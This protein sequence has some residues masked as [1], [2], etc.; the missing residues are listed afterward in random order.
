MIVP[1]VPTMSAADAAAPAKLVRELVFHEDK[2]TEVPPELSFDSDGKA[3]GR[4]KHGDV[5]LP[6]KAINLILNQG[7]ECV[8]NTSG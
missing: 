3:K 8:I 5:A 2:N 6:R 7:E 1:C 4:F